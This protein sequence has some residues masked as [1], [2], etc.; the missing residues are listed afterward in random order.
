MTSKA[1][2]QLR[3]LSWAARQRAWPLQNMSQTAKIPK[4]IAQ[5]VV[6]W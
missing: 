4:I 1:M 3:L 2:N 5:V 6:I